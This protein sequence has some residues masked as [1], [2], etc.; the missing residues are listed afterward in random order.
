MSLD[1]LELAIEYEGSLERVGKRIGYS[2][3]SLCLFRKGRYPN[4][5]L[6][7]NKIESEFGFLAQ[8]KITCPALKGEIHPMVCKRYKDAALSGKNIGGVGFSMVRET[9]AF[10]PRANGGK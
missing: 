7:V 1:L 6:I 2:K 4:P 3:T 10:C 5:A 8:Q 9:C